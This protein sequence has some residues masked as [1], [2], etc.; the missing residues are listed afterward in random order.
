MIITIPIFIFLE[1][2]ETQ[3]VAAQMLQTGGEREGRRLDSRRR[4]I[5]Q[6]AESQGEQS[7]DQV[8]KNQLFYRISSRKHER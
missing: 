1:R 6:E 7:V 2:C 3:S 8:R 5:P 4:R